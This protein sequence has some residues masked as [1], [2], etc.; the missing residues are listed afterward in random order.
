MSFERVGLLLAA[1]FPIALWT[2]CGEVYRPVVLPCS[3]GGLPNCPVE[4]PPSPTAF[5]AVFGVSMNVPAT[6]GNA[7]QIDVGGDSVIGET[8]SS[9]LSAPNIGDNPTH[10]AA[11]PNNAL[12]YVASAGSLLPGGIDLISSFTPAFPSITSGGLGPVQNVSLPTGSLPVFLNTTQNGFMYV[13]NFGSNSVTSI[14]TSLNAVVNTAPVGTN[15][16]A[17]AETPDALRL[18]VANQ[19]SNSISDVDP[20]DLTSTL[21]TGFTGMTPVWLVARADSQKVYVVTQGDGQLVTIDTAT[22]TVTSSLPVGAGANFIFYDTTLNRLYVTNPATG[23]VTVFL[24]SG[25]PNDTPAQIAK[26]SFAAGS[27]ACPAGC[28]PTGVTA[29]NDGTRFYV[30]TYQTASSCPDPFVGAA[31]PC[32]VPRLTVF[33]APTFTIKTTLALLTDPPFSA[34]IGANSYQYATA[35]VAA[36]VPAAFPATFTPATIRFRVFTVAS[37]D[38]SRVYV[39]M[40]DAGA[41]SVVNTLDNNANNPTNNPLPA[42]T[43]V[44][45]LP[46]PFSAGAVQANGQKPF[47]NP[48]FLLTGQ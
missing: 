41:I 8:P 30:A 44:T 15:P 29:M 43:V 35:P 39:S 46:A 21:V 45:D 1:L 42:D 19:G 16:V 32:V 40:C 27:A 7:M 18:Y 23:T 25:G 47:Q 2:A 9:D 33:N 4:A 11:P 3:Q 12:V 38:F 34:N 37:A 26:L 22:D 10:A 17:M 13:A 48:I 31:L 14:S 28:S 6:P 20:V 5:H 36:C 24:A